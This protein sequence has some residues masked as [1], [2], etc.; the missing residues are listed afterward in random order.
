[1]KTRG[2]NLI[3]VLFIGLG[4]GY[5]LSLL[6]HSEKVV[7]HFPVMVRDGEQMLKGGKLD[8]PGHDM[9]PW[10]NEVVVRADAHDGWNVEV[11]TENF[12]FTPEH[13]GKGYAAGEGYALLYMDGRHMAR[14][15][16][17]WYHIFELPPGEHEIRVVLHANSGEELYHDG[18]PIQGQVI[19]SVSK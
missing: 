12:R 5:Y 16:S 14:L 11:R 6:M 8:I 3:L 10:V 19:V 4:A 18:A 1:M 13:I 7:E 2:I 15:L 17:E 9:L